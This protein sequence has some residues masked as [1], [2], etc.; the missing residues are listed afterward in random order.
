MPFF[1]LGNRVFDHEVLLDVFR[2]GVALEVSSETT[3]QSSSC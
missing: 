1:F 2:K 3:K